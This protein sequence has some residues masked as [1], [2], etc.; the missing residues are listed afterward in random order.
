MNQSQTISLYQPMLQSIAAKMVGSMAD[1]EDI[2][3]DT[4]VK[5]LTIDTQKVQNTKAYLIR[6][7]KNNCINHL[8]RLK[9]TKEECLHNAGEIIDHYR[10]KELFKFDK[11]H[12]F[13]VALNILHKKLEPLEKGIFVLREMFDFEYDE[14]QQIFNKKKENCR[15][16]F[17]RA[18]KKLA[19]DQITTAKTSNSFIQSVKKA[20]QVGTS[21]EF[22]SQVKEEINQH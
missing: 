20:C 12:E 16:L 9:K 6:A 14:L 11:E 2:V 22:I 19:A 8:E 5:W 1:A 17:S 4:L 18:K 7:V 15:Q 13:S 3:Q 10:E 21:E